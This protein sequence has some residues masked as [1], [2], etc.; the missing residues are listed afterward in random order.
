MVN[1][2]KK[3]ISTGMLLML[4]A[5]MLSGCGKKSN[6]D[7][8]RIKQKW[9]DKKGDD[10]SPSDANPATSSDVT[11]EETVEESPLVSKDV[12]SEKD[13][14]PIAEATTGDYVR[15]GYF[16]QDNDFDNGAEPLSWK[17]LDV[18][19]DG[20]LVLITE[21]V[22][23]SNLYNYDWE[24]CTW[25]MCDARAML[26]GPFYNYAFSKA[27]QDAILETTLSNAAYT[28]FIH[29]EYDANLEK[30]YDGEQVD[31][32]DGE[33]TVD[34]VYYLDIGEVKQYMPDKNDRYSMPTEFAVNR[35]L[36]TTDYTLDGCDIAGF[37]TRS[38]GVHNTD[39]CYAVGSLSD[40]TEL[41][42][43]EVTASYMGS[44]PVIRVDR[45]KASACENE[46]SDTADGSITKV[47]MSK[48]LDAGNVEALK[49]A[50]VGD[51]VSFG[52]F[53]CDDFYFN[54]PE[55]VSWRVLAIEEGKML[56]ITEYGIEHCKFIEINDSKKDENGDWSRI[57]WE[58][59]TLREQLNGDDYYGKMFTDAEKA[60]ILD[61]TVA[62]PE[63][64]SFWANRYSWMNPSAAAGNDTVDKLFCLDI[65]EVNT[66]FADRDGFMEGQFTD[67]G[68][69]DRAVYPTRHAKGS[70]CYFSVSEKTDGATGTGQWWLRCPSDFQ[71]NQEFTSIIDIYGN[72]NASQK[73][74]GNTVRPA[75]WISIPQ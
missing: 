52:A 26:N 60:L 2:K 49:N 72:F 42:C 68:Y 65:D 64:N 22:I 8:N 37:W 59:S 36:W 27:Q 9:E 29:E 28:D 23:D 24:M 17:V 14:V 54:G 38:P 62:N 51:I 16:E 5:S 41:P 73:D 43:I 44:R 67:Y 19:D 10:S 47:D 11:T 3:I 32:Y 21:Y 69:S 56:L 12:Y 71:A 55:P 50:Q 57:L 25:D 45:A 53:E 39:V 30:Y 70:G 33:D 48:P 74:Y 31:C 35:F 18:E 46:Y 75:M 13:I 34:K 66:Y 20:T 15:F 1:I 40:D 6:I 61:T 63:Y 4:S 7:N 58:N